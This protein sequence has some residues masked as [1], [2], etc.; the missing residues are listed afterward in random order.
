MKINWF[1]FNVRLHSDS[2]RGVSQRPVLD[3][4]PAGV[5]LIP[6]ALG[7]ARALG[8]LQGGGLGGGHLL[9]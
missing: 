5:L 1:E 3:Q 4:A 6:G 7:A 9:G 8:G 2:G